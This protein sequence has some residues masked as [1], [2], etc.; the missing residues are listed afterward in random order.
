MPSTYLKMNLKIT[1]IPMG[2][3]EKGENV[4]RGSIGHRQ[5]QIFKKE[6]KKACSCFSF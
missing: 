4:L 5:R 2:I 6:K 1:S 3:T